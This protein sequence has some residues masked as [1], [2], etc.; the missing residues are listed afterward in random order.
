MV[1]RGNC[2]S[3]RRLFK[4]LVAS[5]GALSSL[6]VA[7][8]K[9]MQTR[10]RRSA[11][12]GLHPG[13]NL[14]KPRPPALREWSWISPSL[15]A[16]FISD[17]HECVARGLDH[18]PSARRSHRRRPRGPLGKCS[19]KSRSWKSGASG[20][21]WCRVRTGHGFWTAIDGKDSLLRSIQA[22][23]A[24]V[25]STPA[26]PA[27]AS[28][29]G[30]PTHGCSGVL[31]IE[32]DRGPLGTRRLSVAAISVQNQRKAARMPEHLV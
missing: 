15:A 28:P 27:S 12:N 23:S 13:L 14:P 2:T 7:A 31:E 16:V 11:W 4:A 1:L 18:V 24:K 20:V 30:A 5:G 10:N 19:Q 25:L 8:S 22:A 21:G 32:A 3:I 26:G 29:T 9:L 6:V 17:P